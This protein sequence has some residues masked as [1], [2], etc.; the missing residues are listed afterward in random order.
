MKIK[1]I[2]DIDIVGKRVMIR[3]DFNV[4]LKDGV[5]TSD[6]RIKAALPTINYALSQNAKV[7][8]VSHL[9]RPK[10]GEYDK[11]LSLQPVADR[12]SDLLSQDVELISSSIDEYIDFNGKNVV[13][14]ENIRFQLGEKKNSDIL[15][16]HLAKQ[17]DVFVMDAFA[18]SHRAQASTYGVAKNAAEVCSGLLMDEELTALSS[19]LKNPENPLVAIVGGAKVSTKLTVLENLVD[20]VDTLI[21]GGGIANTFLLAAGY[22]IG[23]SLVEKNL[24]GIAKELLNK[25]KVMN[26]QIP[27][28]IDV[29][30]ASEF[31]EN[32]HAEV[33]LVTE[34]ADND[35]I[36]D[37]G[38]QTEKLFS[39]ILSTS[40]TIL[41]NGPVGVF[42]FKN[43]GNGTESL[44]RN[45]ISSSAFSVAGGGDTIAAIEKYNIKEKISYM[46]TAGGA[47][48]EFLEGKKL[49]AVEVLL[50]RSK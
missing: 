30:V 2:K 14:Y 5:I 22:P 39:Q 45:I 42:E 33:K 16:N 1:T 47:F 31:S 49:P 7:I 19:A 32:A 13:M 36:L 10:E 35:M 50:E 28:P 15:S 24:V 20:K 12:L 3:V 27:L 17:C 48:L 34:V 43:F 21:V 26:C 37:I 6:V 44:S 9:G 18:T 8:L 40:K 11:H 23:G 38:P 29:R 41:W 46:S 25:S 4:P